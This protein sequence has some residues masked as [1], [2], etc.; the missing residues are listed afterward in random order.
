MWPPVVAKAVAIV[1]ATTISTRRE[2]RRV[3]I[4]QYFL[5]MACVLHAG[6]YDEAA[7]HFVAA[8]H[9]LIP[10]FGSLLFPGSRFTVEKTAVE[11]CSIDFARRI[12][13]QW[14]ADDQRSG[15]F[16]LRSAIAQGGG[17]WTPANQS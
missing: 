11:Q 6:R 16:N 13:V 3:P 5:I 10:H 1:P 7:G 17:R 8:A 9:M 4:E 14:P 15:V 12:G 2:F